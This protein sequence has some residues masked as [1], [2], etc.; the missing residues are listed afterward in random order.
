MLQISLPLCYQTYFGPCR[1]IVCVSLDM[2]VKSTGFKRFN[3]DTGGCITN[4]QILNLK[5]A[6]IDLLMSS[7]F[8]LHHTKMCDVDRM[9][10]K[11]NVMLT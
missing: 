3:L 11:N 6:E 10:G 2:G 5:C 7:F 4:L 8:L 1:V 9:V